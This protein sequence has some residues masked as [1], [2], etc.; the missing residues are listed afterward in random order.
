MDLIMGK[1]ILHQLFGIAPF[2]FLVGRPAAGKER[3]DKG[4]VP[5]TEASHIAV[6]GIS[7]KARFPGEG[8]LHHMEKGIVV[9]AGKYPPFFC[10]HTIFFLIGREAVIIRPGDIQKF[11]PLW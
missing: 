9:L 2:I 1:A 7:G 4:T 3:H 10:D 5:L 6:S 11:F 8:T